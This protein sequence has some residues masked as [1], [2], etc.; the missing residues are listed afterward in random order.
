[1]PRDPLLGLNIDDYLLAGVVGIGGFGRVYLALKRPML[2]K[3][4]LKLLSTEALP[5][6]LEA[7]LG[8][9]FS[10]EARALAVLQH[11]NV[12][13]LLHY[14]VFHNRPYIVTEYIERGVTLEADIAQR[15]ME[16]RPYT[17]DEL[18]ELFRQLLDGLAAAHAEGIVHRDLKPGNIMLQE[19]LGYPRLVRLLD[20]GLAKF[21]A[22]G[23]ESLSS[24]GTPEYMAPEQIARESIGPWTDLYAVGIMAFELFTG[25]L[26]FASISIQELCFNKLDPR[27]DPVGELGE[28]S[29]PEPVLG[30]LRT[31]LARDPL[32]RYQSVTAMRL[33]LQRA[34]EAM[35]ATVLPRPRHPVLFSFSKPTTP[36]HAAPLVRPVPQESDD[37]FHRWLQREERR[38]AQR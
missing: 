9:M 17:K 1:M 26:P 5:T 28:L 29:L 31:A 3:T 11:P 12:V 35:P 32:H 4:A 18:R 34:L 14:G 25:R 16:A 22:S 23:N 36:V 13:R 33:G 7:T 20:F 21:L 27:V 19:A 15:A 8:S 2:M 24:A 30:F 10:A 38:L 6:Q 37:A